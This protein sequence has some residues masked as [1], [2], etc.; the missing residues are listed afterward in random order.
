MSYPITCAFSGVPINDCVEVVVIPI[1]KEKD[2]IEFGFYHNIFELY[3]PYSHPIRCLYI[4]D[5]I[6]SNAKE[7]FATKKL[8]KK[9]NVTI[10]DFLEVIT[11]QSNIPIPNIWAQ[12]EKIESMVVLK[13][14]Y[15]NFVTNKITDNSDSFKNKINNLKNELVTNN[16]YIKTKEKTLTELRRIYKETKSDTIKTL[17]DE[18][19]HFIAEKE[20]TAYSLFSNILNA[21]GYNMYVDNFEEEEL[22]CLSLIKELRAC[23][24]F[25]FK[26]NIMYRPNY[27]GN[28]KCAESLDLMLE[29]NQYREALLNKLKESV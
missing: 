12:D 14:V 20:N 17:I 25:M 10:E 8:E 27:T 26:A 2:E 5:G 21:V 11:G 7:D 24:E 1:H 28:F 6:F 18:H 3:K 9:F 13:E 16:S 4:G 19:V 29:L 22:Q 23:H 15:D